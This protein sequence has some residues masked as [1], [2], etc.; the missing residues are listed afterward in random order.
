MPA[1]IDP[2]ARLRDSFLTAAAEFRADASYPVPW[3]VT[4]I[5]PLALTDPA[6]FSAYVDRVLRERHEAT[7]RPAHFVPMTTLWWAEG[8]QMLGRLAIRHRLTPLLEQSGGHIGYDVRPSARRRGHAT[9]MLAAALPVARSLGIAEALLTCLDTNVGSR[10]VIEANAG[11][12]IG[13]SGP[14][15]R[16]LIPAGEFR[17]PWGRR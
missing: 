2:D 13:M 9:A 10:R 15:R 4:D 8:D 16:Y 11:R 5:D 1:L 7:P 6:A 12:F 17:Q 3:Y 14:K